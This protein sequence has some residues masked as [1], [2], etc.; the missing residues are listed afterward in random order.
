[1]KRF[2]VVCQEC[3]KLFH[4]NRKIHKFCSV[5][6]RVLNWQ[7]KKLQNT[8]QLDLFGENK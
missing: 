4:T 5:N 6:C 3:N 2:K 8:N 7:H 1:M